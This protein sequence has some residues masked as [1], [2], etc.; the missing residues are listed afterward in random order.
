MLIYR[1]IEKNF[2]SHLPSYKEHR[3]GYQFESSQIIRVDSTI[4]HSEITRPTLSLLWNRK[5]VG[6][7]EEYLQAQEHYRQGRNKE[8]LNKCLKA[9]E[10]TMKSICNEKG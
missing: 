1:V 9:F 10:S 7:N 4:I 8:C 5:F 3:I 6:A 2:L